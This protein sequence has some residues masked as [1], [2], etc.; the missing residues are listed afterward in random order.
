MSKH[1]CQ[2]KYCGELVNNFDLY[3]CNNEKSHVKACTLSAT[4]CD[5]FE[6]DDSE[7]VYLVKTEVKGE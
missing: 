5:K 6:Q 3:S 4:A 7:N 1:C 2:C